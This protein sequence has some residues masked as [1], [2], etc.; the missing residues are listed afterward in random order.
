MNVIDN[1]GNNL[2]EISRNEALNIARDR[3]LDLVVVSKNGDK[4]VARITDLAK[5]KYEKSKKL[6]KN[7]G[8]TVQNKEIWFKPNI[9]ERDM[10]LKLEKAKE[11]L[12][13]GGVVKLKLKSDKKIPYTVM[14]ETMRKIIELSSEFSKPINSLSREGRDMS[15]TI[16]AL[17]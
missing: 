11:F 4:V 15:L 2:G 5:L 17:K 12:E 10:R 16:K 3:E 9:Q 1:E 7:K 6:K 8:K 13:K 14:E